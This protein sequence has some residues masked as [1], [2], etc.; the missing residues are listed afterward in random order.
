MR[1]HRDSRRTGAFTLIEV[2]IVV[3]ITGILI[4]IAVPNF[5]RARDTSRVKACISNLKKLDGAKEQFAMDTAKGTGDAVVMGDLVPAYIRE[6]P[7]C[8]ANGSYTVGAIG[9]SPD[10]DAAGHDL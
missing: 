8:P 7:A 4:S 2:M 6:T 3:M 10:C 1:F 9:T 5:I